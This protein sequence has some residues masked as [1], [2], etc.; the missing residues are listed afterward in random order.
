MF[1]SK[2]WT[3]DSRL[4]QESNLAARQPQGATSVIQTISGEGLA[5]DPYVTT[6]GGVEPTTFRTEG[7]DNLH[8]TNH[9]PN[10][11]W[12]QLQITIMLSKSFF[13]FKWASPNELIYVV[14][15]QL[16]TCAQLMLQFSPWQTS[17]V[18]KVAKHMIALE[19]NFYIEGLCRIACL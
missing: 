5:Q 4:L 8:L 7:T 18:T 19:A 12:I 16:M 13:L 9:A 6:R 3:D 17:L 15:E 14:G 2:E 1:T 11:N 10:T